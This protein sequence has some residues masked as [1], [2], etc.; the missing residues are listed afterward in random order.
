MQNCADFWTRGQTLGV[1][2]RTLYTIP[3]EGK[4]YCCD[5]LYAMLELNEVFTQQGSPV[6][7]RPRH[8]RIFASLPGLVATMRAIALPEITS[9]TMM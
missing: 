8:M 7:G 9:Q 6:P 2:Y 4:Y 5:V 1:D 3:S